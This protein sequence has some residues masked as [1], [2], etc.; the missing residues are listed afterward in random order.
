VAANIDRMWIVVAAVP[1]PDFLL[2]DQILAVCE[3]R[4]IDAA[5]LL[6]KTD[7]VPGR[8]AIEQALEDYRCA[9]Y[10]VIRLSVRTGSGLAE[11]RQALRDRASM[12]AGQ[13]GVGKSS[14]TNALLPER[15]LR[16]NE[17]SQ[18]SGLGRHTTTTATLYHLPEGGHLIDS[19]GV[20]VFGLA[21][22]SVRDMA[23][24][25][26]EFRHLLE[27]CQFNDCRHLDDKGCA[28]REAVEQGRISAGRYGRYRR[29]LPRVPVPNV[30]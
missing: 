5:L 28:I 8:E 29:L 17:L 22:M 15:S 2:V 11:L 14:L 30:R 23:Y 27:H 4:H 6:N 18:K 13:S 7:L 10:R 9:G 19:P 21:E 25:Y 12:L 16:V 26:R 1:E 20:N 3:H 24:G